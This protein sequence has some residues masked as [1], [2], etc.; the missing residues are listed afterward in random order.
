[1]A[2]AFE[3]Q[4]KRLIADLV[5]DLS[6]TPEQA[7]GIVGNLAAESGLLAVQERHPIA[8]RGGWGY[9]QW[10]GPRRNAFEA[11]ARAKGYALDSYEANYGFLLRELL[12]TQARS[13]RHLRLT[14]TAKA[15]AET[16]GYWFERFAGYQNLGNANYRNRVQLAERALALSRGS[17]PAPSP[18]PIPVNPMPAPAPAPA[19]V[20]LPDSKPALESKTILTVLA[21]LIVA[22]VAKWAAANNVV[23]PLGWEN[24]VTEFVLS[25]GLVSAGL[26]HKFSSAPVTGS[27]LAQAVDQ[28]RAQQDAA[29][30]APQAIPEAWRDE[31][32]YQPPPG[33]EALVQ[34]VQQLPFSE[35]AAFAVKMVPTLTVARDMAQKL[36]EQRP[37]PQPSTDP[38]DLLKQL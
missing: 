20:P 28:A 8:G 11:W 32:V 25:A 29:V 18:Q 35:M 5:R 31:P 22:W 3:N 21:S 7:A 1:M 17:L 34:M 2:T 9:A 27:S 12:T 14:R 4:S 33:Y 30:E 15:A 23:I 10:T 38:L 36:I 16:F 19:P 6:L 26:F 37:A 13:L 24:A